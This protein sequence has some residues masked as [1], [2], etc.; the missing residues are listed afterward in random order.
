MEPTN[1]VSVVHPDQIKFES[2]KLH[3]NDALCVDNWRPNF[4]E[5]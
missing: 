1:I 3:S 2:Y 4:F 5:A